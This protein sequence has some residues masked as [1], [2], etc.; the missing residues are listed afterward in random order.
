[1]VLAARPD[2]AEPQQ[3]RFSADEFLQLVELGVFDRVVGKVE[4]LEG[5]VY[6]MPAP[7]D[8]HA[9]RSE[10]IN[11]GLVNRFS[12][13]ARVS[14]GNSLRASDISVPMPDFA[15]LP[16][17]YKRLASG[18]PQG[19]ETLLAIEVSDSSRTYD[20]GDKMRIYAASGLREYWV[21]DRV[22]GLVVY[23]EPGPDGYASE[24]VLRSGERIAPLAFPD[25]EFDVAELTG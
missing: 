5:V 20:R 25:V 8:W 11:L 13:R 21:V 19:Q 24:R 15:L 3:H 1:M 14:V 4:L 7:G 16:L 17:E 2:V 22:V 6:E 10:D 12:Q 23:R 18:P 9:E